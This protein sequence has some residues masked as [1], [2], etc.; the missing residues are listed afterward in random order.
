VSVGNEALPTVSVIVPVHNDP[1]G[2]ARCVAAVEAQNYPLDRVQLLVCDN[3]S[4]TPVQLPSPAGSG[5]R[6]ELLVEP[7]PGSY[8]ARNRCL[9]AAV[10]EVL[11]F[12]DA[13]CT[14]DRSWLTRGV[15]TLLATG[16]DLAAGRVAVY[17]MSDRPSPLEVHEI[18]AA[19][20]QQKYVEQMHFGVTANLF[21]RRPVVDDLGPFAEDLTSGGDRE[22]CVRAVGAGRTLVYADDA[23]VGHP[24][25]SSVGEVW[26][27]AKRVRRGAFEESRLPLS[28]GGWLR[29]LVPPLGA[30]RRAHD[31][32]VPEGAR[33]KYVVGEVTAHYLNVAADIPYVFRTGRS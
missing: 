13:D 21:V 19:F 18:V 32:R 29:R 12:T 9:D 14:P 31:P 16:S 1:V 6:T 27:K 2:I 24:A 11:A 25:R 20:P 23:V 8:R 26:K 22:F 15:A 30:L 10:G 7:V 33:W 3:A 4:Q 28:R 17:T 5:L